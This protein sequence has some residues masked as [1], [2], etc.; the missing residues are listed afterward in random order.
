MLNPQTTVNTN[1][2]RTFIYRPFFKFRLSARV[3]LALYCGLIATTVTSTVFLGKNKFKYREEISSRI[4]KIPLS[5]RQQLETFLRQVIFES[6]FGFVLFGE[7]PMALEDFLEID[8]IPQNFISNYYGLDYEI[9]LFNLRL[10]IDVW[11]KYRHLFPSKKYHLAIERREDGTTVYL[12]NQ[13]AFA[14]TFEKHKQDFVNVLGDD[15]TLEKLIECIT[16]EKYKVIEKLKR[17]AALLGTLLGYGR[18][19]SWLYHDWLK[20]RKIKI[21]RPLSPFSKIPNPDLSIPVVPPGFGCNPTSEETKELR[22]Q[23]KKTRQ[24]IYKAYQK[25]DFLEITLQKFCE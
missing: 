5:E 20:L 17:N 6:S 3:V 21:V 10:G 13:T 15:F 2:D 7:K 4:A 23:Y 8:D 22:R 11:K 24:R 19:N 12:I 25:G 14:R 9:K 1:K 16:S 18:N